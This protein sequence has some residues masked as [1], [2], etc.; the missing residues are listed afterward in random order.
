MI[1]HQYIEEIGLP[2]RERKIR[3]PYAL[4][5]L[6]IVLAGAGWLVHWRS[7]SEEPSS[8]RRGQHAAVSHSRLEQAS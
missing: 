8:H 3:L 2:S 7:A 1:R 4:A 6:A 5:L